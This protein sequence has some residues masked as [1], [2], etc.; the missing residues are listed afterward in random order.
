MCSLSGRYTKMKIN[1][2]GYDFSVLIYRFYAQIQS[3]TCVGLELCARTHITDR[4]SLFS[5][6]DAKPRVKYSDPF[7]ALKTLLKSSL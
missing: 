3:T 1:F 4:S 6:S 5:L 7:F 2:N